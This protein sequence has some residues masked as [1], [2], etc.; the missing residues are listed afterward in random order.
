MTVTTEAPVDFTPDLAKQLRRKIASIVLDMAIRGDA[1]G[2]PEDVAV[3]ALVSRHL[4]FHH[5]VGRLDLTTFA[6]GAG[7][8]L[9]WRTIEALD[10]ANAAR[11]EAVANNAI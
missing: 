1:E 5:E 7:L 4:L 2:I 6:R 8:E 10:P 9:V 11:A 3:D